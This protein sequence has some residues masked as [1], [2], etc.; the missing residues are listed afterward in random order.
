MEKRV[1]MDEF[2]DDSSHFNLF[3]NSGN[4][5]FLGSFFC[6]EE[7]NRV[8]KMLLAAVATCCVMA[9]IGVTGGVYYYNRLLSLF[10]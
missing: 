3:V 9:A 2:Q 10:V 8:L 5:L 4:L 7:S 1:P 6:F